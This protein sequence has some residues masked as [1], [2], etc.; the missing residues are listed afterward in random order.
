MK[1]LDKQWRFLGQEVTAVE[2]LTSAHVNAVY[3]LNPCIQDND[4]ETGESSDDL[5]TGSI[6]PY[7]GNRYL[8]PVTEKV[9]DNI[10]SICTAARCKDGNPHC[11][12]YMGQQNWE[13]DDACE[14]YF[15]VTADRPNPGHHK[16]PENAPAGMKNL[17]AT[18]YAN[19]LLQ[20]WFHDPAFRDAIYRCRFR[21]EED[22]STNALYQLQLL[23]AHLDRGL[24]SFYNPLSLVN[25]LKLDTAMQQDAQEF[26]NLF[27][28]RI[29]N[30]FQRQHD[31]H[32]KTF[33]AEQFQ[34]IY[35][36]NTT[37]KNCMKTSV[38]DCQFYEL[39][40][41]IRDNCTLMDCLEEFVEP[42]DLTGEDQY[43]CSACCSLQDASREIKLEKLPN[44]LNI[45]LMRFVYD[46]VTW[47][48]K[49]SKDTIRFPQVIDVS[50]L[51]RTSDIAE[52][53][54]TAVLVHSGPSAH[55]GH[56]LAHVLQRESNKWFV[57]NDEEV[58][59]FHGTTFDP[60]DYSEVA[61]SD[62]TNTKSKTKR[63]A[64]KNGNVEIDMHASA[65][66]S[67]NAYMLTYVRKTP[68]PSVKPC[69][70]P[71]ETLKIVIQDNDLYEKDLEEY[72]QY[73]EKIKQDFEK[74]RSVRQELYQCWHVACDQDKGCY[75]S[76]Q[77]LSDFM[78]LEYKLP[79]VLDSSSISCEHGK[80]CP[81]AVLKSKRISMQ[82]RHIL[83]E[84]LQIK[85]DPFLTTEHICRSCV[86]NE[87]QDK[88]YNLM[89]R[90]DTDEFSRKVKLVR[91]PAAVWVSKAWLSDWQKVCPRFHTAHSSTTDDPSPASGP[92]IKDVLCQHHKLSGDKSRRKLINKAALEVLTRVF[93]PL[94]LPDN[95]MSECDACLNQ[96]QPHIDIQKVLAV[97]ATSE[98][99]DFMGIVIRGSRISQME[100][101]ENYYV[102]SQEGF[103]KKWLAYLKRPMSNER[104][105]TIDN[106]NLHCKHG[107]FVFDLNSDVDMVNEDIWVIKE[108]EWAHLCEL[109]GGGPKVVI[110]V[111]ERP[112]LDGNE[113]GTQLTIESTPPLCS[114][115]RN[116]RILAFSTTTFVVRIH[117]SDVSNAQGD[118]MPPESDSS[119]PDQTGTHSVA[120]LATKRKLAPDSGSDFGTRRSK[121]TKPVKKP[122]KEIKIPVSKWDTVM[123]IKLKIMQKTNVVPLYQKLMH[124]KSELDN[125]EETI[126]DLEIPPNAVLDMVAFDQSTED[127][128]LSSLQ[129]VE[130]IPGDVGGFGGTGLAGYD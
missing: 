114:A 32:L 27:M 5:S 91:N 69:T 130:P 116:E 126:A 23:F 125:N 76:T 15:E 31:D 4:R 10:N 47:T 129:D 67:R 113:T 6:F 70:P 127:F 115:C 97:R 55:S 73:K 1:K 50:G 128:I 33:I 61:S 39:M 54:L 66:S 37:C 102:V 53:E 82:A 81:R 71:T 62:K 74:S 107:Q 122:Y 40:L 19:S 59:E 13:G 17:G 46:N 49:K 121:R 26:C 92:Y 22:F 21:D 52:Y 79:K 28:A 117:S 68:E 105:S 84:Q 100:Q 65:F 88:L 111:T 124:G 25:S 112:S 110:S 98:K 119:A 77:A 44:V 45:Q 60:E 72:D 3:G 90:H 48:K 18:C 108:D 101:G 94:A 14:R 7:C 9:A 30:Q 35:S 51:L 75:V 103:M 93:G 78:E 41:N 96:L 8:R 43:F 42:E 36:Y 85:L 118:S 89:H 63:A 11:L 87:C 38:R 24:K 83:E 34:G 2:D 80:L 57:L 106:A 109:Y 99:Q 29:D 120:S 58:E 12:N 104:P 95:D 86:E 16:R 20:V 64:A 123:D 56:F